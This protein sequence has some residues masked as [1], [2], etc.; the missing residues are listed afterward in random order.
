MSEKSW[1]SGSI[2]EVYTEHVSVAL[3]KKTLRI[4]PVEAKQF[5]F[6]GGPPRRKTRKQNPKKVLCV[7][8]VG[9]TKS[10]WFISI[11]LI[12]GRNKY[13]LIFRTLSPEQ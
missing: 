4:F 13:H 12:K 8:A 1:V 9:L 2:F 5:A 6:S 3:G 7:D 11:K 10:A